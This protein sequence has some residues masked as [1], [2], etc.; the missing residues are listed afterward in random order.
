[1]YAELLAAERETIT[2]QVAL[3]PPSSEYNYTKNCIMT[4]MPVVPLPHQHMVGVS[5]RQLNV[6]AA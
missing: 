3:N 2:T 6:A 4:A 1:M 5:A